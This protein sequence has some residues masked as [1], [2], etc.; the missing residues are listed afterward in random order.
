MTIHCKVHNKGPGAEVFADSDG[1]WVTVEGGQTVDV[2]VSEPMFKT[3]KKAFDDPN[4][5]LDLVSAEAGPDKP[6]D[7]KESVS[8]LVGSTKTAED[9]KNEREAAG[10]ET[11]AE[12]D[13]VEKLLADVEAKSVNFAQLRSRAKALLGSDFPTGTSPKMDE[14][15][16]LLH[17]AQ[18]KKAGA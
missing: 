9:L 14:I 5:R 12:G 6:K 10:A 18:R 1:N 8:D 11:P 13:T 17:V 16:E 3:L 7:S 15:V 4:Y 2:E